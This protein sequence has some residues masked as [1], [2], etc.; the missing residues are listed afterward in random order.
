MNARID[1]LTD[2]R[3]TRPAFQ[4]TYRKYTD[5]RADFI[6]IQAD[7]IEHAMRA[8]TDHIGNTQYAVLSIRPETPVWITEAESESGVTREFFSDDHGLL[9][10]PGT[11][12]RVRQGSGLLLTT[13]NRG[14]ALRLFQRQAQATTKA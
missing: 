12:Y 13:R 9:G 4:I 3:D 1:H 8:L 6:R 2:A 14:D 11:W 5:T 10:V 7:N